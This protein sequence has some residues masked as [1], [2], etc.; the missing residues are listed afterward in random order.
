MKIKIKISKKARRRLWKLNE[1]SH[2][3]ID[4]AIKR[5]AAK[6]QKEIEKRMREWRREDYGE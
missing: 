6:L 5:A 3:L 4:A 2:L 1:R